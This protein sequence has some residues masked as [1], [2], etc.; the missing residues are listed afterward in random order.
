MR[1]Q[2]GFTDDQRFCASSDE[3]TRSPG[4]IMRILERCFVGTSADEQFPGL[5]TL[6][7]MDR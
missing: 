1:L 3:R 2:R 5:L 7:G 6:L 4:R